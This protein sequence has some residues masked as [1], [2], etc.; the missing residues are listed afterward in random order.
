MGA[1]RQARELAL[2]LL[3]SREINRETDDGSTLAAFRGRVPTSAL[4]YAR[5]LAAGVAAN[6]GE[7]ERLI[8]EKS[9]NWRLDRLARI[10]RAILKLAVYELLF[11]DDVPPLVSIDEAVE[12]AKKFSTGQSG[13]FINGLLDEIRRRQGKGDG[14]E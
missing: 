4:D 11:E 5:R 14:K 10:D 7:L 12:L 13:A 8:G 2:M 9:R 6:S 1:R 3:Y